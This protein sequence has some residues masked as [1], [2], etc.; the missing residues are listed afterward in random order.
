MNARHA[1]FAVYKFP[2]AL[3][4]VLLLG[5][6]ACGENGG[7]GPAGPTALAL[8]TPPSTSAQNRVPFP[9]QPVLQLRD[10][11]GKP[12]ALPGTVITA[13]ITAGGGTLAGT[14]TATTESTGEATFAHLSISGTAGARTLTFSATGLTS[15]AA[16][17]TLVAGVATTLVVTAG[18]DQYATPGAPL[19]TAPS[20]RVTDA[21]GNGVSGVAVTFAVASGGGSISAASATTDAFGV[22]AAGIWTLGSTLGTNSLTA[23][24]AL[25]VP[26]VTFTATAVPALQSL[27]SGE[28]SCG[29]TMDGTAYCWGYNYYGQV[30]DGTTTNRLTP[31]AVAGGLTFT[32]LVSGALHTCGLTAGG[33]AYCWG[34]NG[35]GRLGDGTAVDRS[36]PVG[37]AG[38]LTFESLTGGGVHTCGLTTGGATYCWGRNFE[39]QLGIGT[40]TGP[41]QCPDVGVPMPADCSTVPVAI[42]GGLTF[43]SLGAGG[44]HT[45]GVTTDGAVYCWGRNL[46]G[47]LGDGTTTQRSAPIAVTVEPGATFQS[48]DG[49]IYHTC[50]LSSAAAAYC[51]G[52]NSNGQLGDGTLTQRSTPVSVI[53][54]RTFRSV[55]GGGYHTCGV[56]T[57]DVAYCWGYELYGQLGNLPSG[58]SH[59]SPQAVAEGPAYR[60]LSAGGFHTCGVTKGSVAYC[61]GFNGRGAIG[62]G[63][64]LD[65][66]WPVAVRW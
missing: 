45:C 15:V 32:N 29:L 60:S 37:V 58:V 39:G 34:Y 22:A 28:H 52:Q 10:A 38:G 61:W 1:S 65:R 5:G 35:G 47:Q 19:A 18:D 6:L 42:L 64:T 59:P 13:T 25:A 9:T 46:E 54:G 62:D 3:A 43:Q 20:V 66:Y 63:T 17:I 57:D 8:T 4:A 26:P 16:G 14:Q 12:V 7:V 49:G 48:L 36:T 30:G 23:A 44:R 40:T 53:G 55:D 50:A 51:W 56:T 27:V 33:V 21:D 31:E 11:E 24:A 41:E 2:G